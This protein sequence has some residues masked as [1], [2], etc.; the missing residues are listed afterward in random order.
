MP[1]RFTTNNEIYN[2]LISIQKQSSQSYIISIGAMALAL[3]IPATIFYIQ[4]NYLYA[5][6]FIIFELIFIY[7]AYKIRKKAIESYSKIKSKYQ[8]REKHEK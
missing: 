6:I 8:I 4:K 3:A 7:L 2:K 1:K 5:L